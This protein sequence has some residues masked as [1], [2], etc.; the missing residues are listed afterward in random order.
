MKKTLLAALLSSALLGCAVTSSD[1]PIN[2]HVE[3][4]TKA[5]AH[6]VIVLSYH[7]ADAMPEYQ[8]YDVYLYLSELP[9]SKS[10]EICNFEYGN[11]CQSQYSVW[12]NALRP[13]QNGVWL[14]Y[15]IKFPMSLKQEY[16]VNLSNIKQLANQTFLEWDKTENLYTKEM[17]ASGQRVQ[18]GSVTA[19][20]YKLP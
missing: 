2:N 18:S 16:G 5:G 20:V 3:I 14:R 12:E 9:E 8:N 6:S 17:F 19:T 13:D 4:G 7:H 15:D 1:T 10:F 11:D